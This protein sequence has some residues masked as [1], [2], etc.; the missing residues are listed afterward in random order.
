MELVKRKKHSVLAR[1]EACGKEM[2]IPYANTLRPHMPAIDLKAAVRC[3]CGEYH[4]LI[5]EPENSRTK[6]AYYQSEDKPLKCPRCGSS[7]LHAG[8]KGFSLGKAVAGG[9]LI[10]PIGLLGGLIGSKKTMITCL[11]CGYRWQA[12]KG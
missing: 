9:V 1:C 2:E 3:A 6:T 10:G 12:G 11:K 5:V 8:D 4:N 7:Q